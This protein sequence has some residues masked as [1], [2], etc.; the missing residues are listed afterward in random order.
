M[1]EPGHRTITCRTKGEVERELKRIGYAV[2]RGTY[3]KPWD[4]L[5]PE[6]IDSYLQHGAVGWEA[7]TR[8]SYANALQPAREWF[9]HRKARAVAREDVEAYR[10]HLL[11]E[12]RRRGGPAGTGLGARSVNLALQQLSAAYDLAEIDGRVARNPVRHVKR[13]RHDAADR[14]TWT[15]EQVRQFLAT[16]AG[17]RLHAC[18][19]L[20][21]L[22]LRRAE[23]LGLRWGDVDY[24][25]GTVTIARTRV[26]VNG[27]VIEKSPKSRRSARTLP[28]FE[29]VTG[30]LRALYKRQLKERLA[31]GPAYADSG[32]IAADELGEPLGIERYSDE[33]GRIAALADLPPVRLHDT[34][35]TVNGALERTG[36]SESL[37]AAWLGHTVTV[38][39]TSYLRPPADLAPVS[40]AIGRI[41]QAV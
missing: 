28:L 32:Y 18:W 35:A 17:D 15:E 38:N 20:S 2:D 25:A 30:A 22:G 27:Q 4:G 8:L 5:V 19:L 37:R 7:N 23:V 34:R 29:P 33:F 40:D 31:A 26:L 10:D 1:R 12:G 9:A 16:A 14:G 13:A 41:F 39:K 24:T 21:L 36:V 11:T 6:L 3:V